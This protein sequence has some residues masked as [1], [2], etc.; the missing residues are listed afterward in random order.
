VAA[1][2]DDHELLQLDFYLGRPLPLLRSPEAVATHLI[3]THGA[4]VVETERW[5]TAAQWLPLDPGGLRTRAIGADIVV[6][7]EGRR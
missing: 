6:V 1:L 3:R 4:V 2:A 7:T 5:R